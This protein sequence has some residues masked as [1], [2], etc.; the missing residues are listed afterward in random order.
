MKII[1]ILQKIMTVPGTTNDIS[2]DVIVNVG[3]NEVT[4]VLV[5]LITLCDVEFCIS[6]VCKSSH[7]W[8][9]ILSHNL[10]VN[11]L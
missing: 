11:R 8:N 5:E 2:V 10:A 1:S 3:V 4:H 7:V 9:V 6:R